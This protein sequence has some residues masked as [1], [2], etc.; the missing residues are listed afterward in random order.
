[1]PTPI[2]LQLALNSPLRSLFDY[3]APS[4]ENFTRGQRVEV[5][6]GK[7]K[8][9]GLIVN[10]SEH[11]NIEASRLKNIT[12]D[13]D[14]EASISEDL[15][16]FVIWAANYYHHPIGEALFHALP[17][18]LRENK[19]IAHKDFK[20]WKA[21]QKGLL[22]DPTSL[23]RAG[24]QIE[25]LQLLQTHTQGLGQKAC[26]AV[27]I[28]NASLKALENKQL[29]HL[30]DAKNPSDSDGAIQKPASPQKLLR[31][32]PLNLNQE[33]STALTSIE[34]KLNAHQCFLLYGVTG[35][36]KTEVY[37]QSIQKVLEQ[38]KQALVLV[39]E[40]GLTPQTLLRFQERFTCNI[41][42]M[43][44]GLTEHE[45]YK[46]W[47]LAKSQ[48]A[49]IIIGTRSAIF[50][51]IPKLGII[52][53]DEEHDLSYKQ[54]EGFR[55][56]A[57][58]LA[59][60]RAQREK[61][62]IVLGSATPSFESLLNVEKS[63][64][65]LLELKQRASQAQQ[66]TAHIVDT[67]GKELQ[68][69]LSQK[70]IQ[71][72]R[73]HLEQQHQVLVF[74]NRRGYAP[75]LICEQCQWLAS[76]PYCD[77]RFTFHKTKNRLICH[78]CNFQQAPI[79]T[80]PQCHEGE[81]HALGQGTEKVEE[82]LNMHFKKYP[83]IRIDKDST[84]KK[85]DMQNHIK[86]ILHGD[87]CVLVGTQMLTK[88][89]HFPKINLVCIID[90]DQG[91]FS[92]D[93]RS[94]EKMAQTLIQ[95]TGRAGR[96]SQHSEV[97]L[98]TE[99]PDHPALQT[100]MQHGYSEFAKISME[101]R[102]ALQYPPYGYLC[103][104]RADAVHIEQSIQFLDELKNLMQSTN[105]NPLPRILGPAPAPMQKRAGR[106]RAQLLLHSTSRSSLHALINYSIEQTTHM[107]SSKKVRWSIDI[108]P[109]EMF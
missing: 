4:S 82:V 67:R 96:E 66:P 38:G 100:L 84:E 106:H 3:K 91:F 94:L 62:P 45:R 12:R 9:I 83:V 28:N 60:V 34:S 65:R 41:A 15:L 77:A 16:D 104:L 5:T 53:V 70:T 97:L 36:G 74:I 54:Q 29:I 99:L 80:C 6:F 46:N 8:T 52:I 25:A 92:S 24:K 1:M 49:Q 103:L 21:T 89:H 20:V 35:S 37:L 57:R 30:T 109:L 10:I 19:P 17:Q 7:Q 76:C 98:Q 13:I 32:I 71:S 78:H 50:A 88:G 90:S 56:S 27:G 51:E 40:I 18:R 2:Y 64:Y 14:G 69:G 47:H 101:D 72:I 95:I 55:Y 93:F 42:N 44:S 33:Q 61:I 107:Q 85:N 73:H 102:K 31:S 58:D 79:H 87:P 48:Q 75:V 59:I 108:D 11:S 23:G 22:I 68:G 26:L 39:P 86:Q 43:H 63:R 105:L 81:M